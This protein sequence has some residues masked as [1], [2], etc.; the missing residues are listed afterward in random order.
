MMGD[1]IVLGQFMEIMYDL[2]PVCPVPLLN[3]VC[4]KYGSV[5]F[6]PNII[7]IFI[8]LTYIQVPEIANEMSALHSKAAY[9]DPQKFGDMWQY[10][11]RSSLDIAEVRSMTV[12]MI[13]SV[14][15]DFNWRFT[16]RLERMPAMLLWLVWFAVDL[17]RLASGFQPLAFGL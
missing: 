11:P 7:E 9:D 5:S 6:L 12:L 4:L 8:D 17:R 1:S 2:K 16:R 10:V 13:V 3:S 14:S 15:C